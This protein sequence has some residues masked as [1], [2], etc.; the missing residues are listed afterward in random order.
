MFIFQN[1]SNHSADSILE[2]AASNATNQKS[3]SKDKNDDI[4]SVLLAHEKQNTS[5]CWTKKNYLHKV[6]EYFNSML[7]LGNNAANAIKGQDSSDSSDDEIKDPFKQKDD[8]GA[9]GKFFLA[10]IIA[11][12]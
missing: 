8:I 7:I 2:K 6:S 3:N 11:C 10:N 9:I 1:D 4:M 5:K 12:F